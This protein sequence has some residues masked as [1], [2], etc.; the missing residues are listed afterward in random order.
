VITCPRTGRQWPDEYSGPHLKRCTQ[1]NG[2]IDTRH[3]AWRGD[4]KGAHPQHPG[5]CPPQ[6]FDIAHQEAVTPAPPKPKVTGR[7]LLERN[8]WYRRNVLDKASE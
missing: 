5:P 1:C 6:V 4:A 3:E 7:Q 2:V 8:D